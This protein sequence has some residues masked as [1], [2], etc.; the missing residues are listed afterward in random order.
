MTASPPRASSCRR[1]PGVTPLGNYEGTEQVGLASKQTGGWT[2]I[3]C[4]GLEVSPEVLRAA[5]RLAGAHVY[6]DSNDVIS[7]C[8]G[9]V[10]H[11]RHDRRGEDAEAAEGGDGHEIWSVARSPEGH[12]PAGAADGEG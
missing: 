11:P 4:G 8:P 9:F 2:S 6:C 7:A 12:G 1:R 10:S 5:A 3:F